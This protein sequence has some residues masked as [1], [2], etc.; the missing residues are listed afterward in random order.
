M[1]T[2]TRFLTTDMRASIHAHWQATF[3]QN[4]HGIVPETLVD[5]VGHS[6]D[7]V[8]EYSAVHRSGTGAL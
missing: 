8:H 4:L 3:V 1:T 6:V 5:T 2:P 7:V